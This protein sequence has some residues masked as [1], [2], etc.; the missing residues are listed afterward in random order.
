VKTAKAAAKLAAAAEPEYGETV[1]EEQ[2]STSPSSS[3]AA[4]VSL[5]LQKAMEGIVLAE[6][7]GPPVSLR[8]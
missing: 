8:R 6:I 2:E 5:S 7:L 1:D 4:P 3:A